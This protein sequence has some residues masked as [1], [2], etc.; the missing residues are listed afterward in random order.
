VAKKL[1]P[2]ESDATV[3][4]AVLEDWN[5]DAGPRPLLTYQMWEDGIFELVD[6]WCEV[7]KP[8]RR[9]EPQ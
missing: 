5:S 7:T 4:Q 8:E 2:Y 1:C 6:L 3:M 9:T